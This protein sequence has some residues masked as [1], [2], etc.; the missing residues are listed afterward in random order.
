MEEAS[1][2][3]YIAK[4]VRT[5]SR[6][7]EAI[8]PERMGRRNQLVIKPRDRIFS[9][10]SYTSPLYQ[11]GGPLHHEYLA[12]YEKAEPVIPEDTNVRPDS[13]DFTM[14]DLSQAGN[15]RQMNPKKSAFDTSSEEEDDDQDGTESVDDVS[16][17]THDEEDTNF[18]D[19]IID[20]DGEDSQA[21]A[22]SPMPRRMS[23]IRMS[24]GSLSPSLIPRRRTTTTDMDFP[25]R[26]RKSST[27]KITKR[28]R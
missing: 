18:D 10:S 4:A 12:L 20:D 22:Y 19:E 6:S 15:P 28:R 7:L 17:G 27:I 16:E 1:K 24:S 26:A 14:L 2:I 23:R 9:R 5:S 11:V 3:S 21:G 13:P 8:D 25:I